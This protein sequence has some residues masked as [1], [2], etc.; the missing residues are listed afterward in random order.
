MAWIHSFTVMLF[1]SKL[2]SL[3][4]SEVNFTNSLKFSFPTSGT[5]KIVIIASLTASLF[6]SLD[7]LRQI[8]R[9]LLNS[10]DSTQRISFTLF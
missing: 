8:W 2:K 10:E 7:P 9:D 3:N 5:S 4:E 6:A 1:L